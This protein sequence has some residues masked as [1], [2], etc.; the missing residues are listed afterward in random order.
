LLSIG[1]GWRWLSGWSFL[2]KFD[3]EL[4]GSSQTY[5]GTAQLRYSW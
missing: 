4:S 5:A 1:A 3:S 2:A